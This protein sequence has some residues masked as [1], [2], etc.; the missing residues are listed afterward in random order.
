MPK[1]IILTGGGTAGHVTPNLAL[2]PYLLADNWEI[3]YLGMK[4]G[5][6]RE[7]LENIPDIQFHPI[8]SGK[9]RRYVDWKNISDMYH[10]AKGYFE[11]KKLIQ[12]IK[13][14]IVFSKGGYVSVPVVIASAHQE[15]P[16]IIHESDL[17]PGLANRIC[18]K[19]ATKICTSFPETVP[20]F[21]KKKVV[22]TGSPIRDFL[23]YGSS[24]K[25]RQITGFTN[26]LPIILV[27]GG[28]QGSVFLNQLIL[29]TL[30][31][32]T[33]DYQ[34]LLVTGSTNQIDIPQQ[35]EN[36]HIASYLRTEMA[37]CLAMADL[38]ISRA[39]A[40]TLFE[41]LAVKKPSILIPLS[42]K[43]SRGDQVWNARNF[44]E[45]GF[46]IV[47][48]QSS[49]TPEKFLQTIQTSLCNIDLMKEEMEKFEEPDTVG[50]LKKM[51]EE[52]KKN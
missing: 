52:L 34:V 13:P 26:D 38:V 28:S 20:F 49:I 17:T 12:A 16:V 10:I 30:P 39:G 35:G 37:D 21:E 50:L 15:I 33:R 45:N 25:G 24:E 2:I 51:F 5:F 14:N 8:D 27:L 3:H 32:L 46:S 9:L 19:Y 41:L 42:T 47:L 36:Y 44:E 23:R 7:L 31:A 43:A 1:K 4:S 22:F 18:A 48:E 11:S 40:N 6:E 29:D